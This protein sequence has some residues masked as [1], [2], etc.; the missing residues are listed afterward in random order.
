MSETYYANFDYPSV[1]LGVTLNIDVSGDENE[2]KY[3]NIFKSGS[4]ALINE[5]SLDKVELAN[6]YDAAWYEIDMRKRGKAFSNEVWEIGAAMNREI[7]NMI[8]ED[9]GK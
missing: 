2:I 7:V 8:N 4:S 1:S 3:L 9:K 6:I 5:S